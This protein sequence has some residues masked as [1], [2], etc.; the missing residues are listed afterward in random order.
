MS[1]PS[2]I[3]QKIITILG[4]KKFFYVVVGVLVAGAGWFALTA[5]YPMA[6]DESFH[7]G[8]IQIYAHQWSPI[9][10]STP[11]DSGQFGEL[12]HDPSYL[13]H[14]LMS[15]PYRL[16]GLFVHNFVGQVIIMRFLN[17]GLFTGGL[18]AFRKLLL[19]IG[20]SSA[21]VNFSLLMLVLLPVTPFLAAHINYDNMLFLLVPI[22]LLLVLS[23]A[24]TTAEDHQMSIRGLS[25]VITLGMLTSL[26]KYVYLPIFVASLAY[27]VIIVLRSHPKEILS[28]FVKSTHSL[29]LRIKIGLIV[30]LAVSSGL[31]LQ[32]YAINVVKYHNIQ[33]DCNRVETLDHCMQY[34]P[35]ARNYLLETTAKSSSS[36]PSHDILP[37]FLI[38]WIE[39]LLYRLYFAINYDFTEY[40]PFPIPVT[41]ACAICIIGITLAVIFWHSILRM[42]IH[43]WLLV[44]VIITYCLSLLYVNYTEYLRFDQTVAING[45][46]LI[47]LLPLIFAIVGLAFKSLLA[48]FWRSSNSMKSSLAVIAI[49]LALQGGGALTYLVYSNPTWYW[50]NNPLTGLNVTA[51]KIITPLIVGAK[52]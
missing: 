14:Y 25:L 3:A 15:F 8:I 7:F 11:P 42:T 23:C 48:R 34:G 17:I 4:S 40:A 31:F 49:L 33:P 21:L 5:A 16:I 20:V 36:R 24:Q 45:R 18:F 22:N 9:L 12:T 32:R 28:N 35:W 29:Q 39:S 26:V 38:S 13:Y 19:R 27:L 47:P 51:Q 30:M 50:G 1:K 2:S 10:T 44:A 41:M 6:F 43:I 37:V 52:K 46:Y